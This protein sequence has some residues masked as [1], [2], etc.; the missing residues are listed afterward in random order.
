MTDLNR[1][2]AAEAARRLARREI[3]AEALLRDCLARIDAREARVRAWQ[4]LARD[5]LC[6][7]HRKRDLVR[8][9]VG[10]EVHDRCEDQRQQ[11]AVLASEG[12]ANKQQ[13]QR[14]RGQQ[15]CRFKCVPHESD[16][17]RIDAPPNARMHLR[18]MHRR[19]HAANL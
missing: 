4:F 19:A 8:I 17:K 2:S 7:I 1:L 16:P 13:H 14:E 12:P 18:K 11:H 3:T 5:W 9:K 10:N 15:K 6:T